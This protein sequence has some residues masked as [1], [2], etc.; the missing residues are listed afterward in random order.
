MRSSEFTFRLS[1]KRLQGTLSIGSYSSPGAPAPAARP[2]PGL[3]GDNVCVCSL[4]HPLKKWSLRQIRGGST[5]DRV[6][7]SVGSWRL[8]HGVLRHSK[9]ARC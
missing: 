3:P 5:F 2:V 7:K 4:L 9:G 6:I 8:W 1:W